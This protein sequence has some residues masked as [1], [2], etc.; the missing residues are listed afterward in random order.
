M[1]EEIGMVTGTVREEMTVDGIVETTTRD[2]LVGMM[3]TGTEVDEKKT[4]EDAL[5]GVNVMMALPA[6]EAAAVGKEVQVL[7][8]THQS[9][10]ERSLFH[11]ENGKLPVGMFTHQATNSIR[12]CKPSR[13]ACSICRVRTVRRFHPF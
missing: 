8:A 9:Q 1:E 13:L 6:G 12:Q 11:R 4:T 5:L 3:K 7:N 10:K 2:R